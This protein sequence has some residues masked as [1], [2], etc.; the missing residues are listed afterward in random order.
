MK[1]SVKLSLRNLCTNDGNNANGSTG[2]PSGAAA[3][4]PPAVWVDT[5]VVTGVGV[6]ACAFDD[7]VSGVGIWTGV[8]ACVG[9]DVGAGF[10]TGAVAAS[11]VVVCFA[12][13]TFGFLCVGIFH[14]IY[15][16]TIRFLV[17]V[18]CILVVIHV[19]C[20]DASIRRTIVRVPANSPEDDKRQA[21]AN[22][23]RQPTT[24]Y[25]SLE[26]S[27]FLLFRCSFSKI[28]P[29]FTF[30]WSVSTMAHN[31]TSHVFHPDTRELFTLCTHCGVR[32]LDETARVPCPNAPAANAGIFVPITLLF[33][34]LSASFL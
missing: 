9:A 29:S 31:F 22:D 3:S 11:S 16:C 14:F 19:N 6:W 5:A 24:D 30:F 33:L 20:F 1:V 21:A 13:F 7:C 25:K 18:G 32:N 15:F 17:S 27:R 4:N 23:N 10:G 28:S 8:W 34:F 12:T 2:L 26:V